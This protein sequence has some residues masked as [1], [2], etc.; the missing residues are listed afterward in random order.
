MKL[1]TSAQ[2][3]QWDLFTM[4]NESVSEYNLMERAAAGAA[5]FI[6]GQFS[7]NLPVYVFCGKGNNGADGLVISRKLLEGGFK[8][9]TF[10]IEY[11]QSASYLFSK[12]YEVLQ[13][14]LSS[15]IIHLNA[16]ELPVLD[17]GAIIIDA[18]FGSSLR[19][20]LPP[21]VAGII[22]QLNECRISRQY[23]IVAIDI[24]T[25]LEA[26]FC[27]PPLESPLQVCITLSFQIPKCSF[28][29][30][31]TG[32]YCGEVNILDIG[33]DKKFPIDQLSDYFLSDFNS[34]KG[35][36]KKRMK[37]AHK[38]NFGHSLII[39]GSKGKTGAAVLAAKGC[40]HAGA[41]LVTLFIHKSGLNTVQISV[42][43]AMAVESNET[44]FAAGFDQNL[45]L[46][47]SI[48]VGPGLG[49]QEQTKKNLIDLLK[50]YTKP[51]ILDADA[52]N[53]LSTCENW[54]TLIPENSI[55][56]PHPGEFDR[57]MGK[58]PT[59]FDRLQKQ[60]RLAL[61]TRSV[62]ILKGAYTSICFPSGKTWFNASGNPGMATG[63]SGDTLTGILCAL[64][65][66]GYSSENASR[67]GVYVHGLAADLAAEVH[68]QTALS[69]GM[70]SDFLGK[71]FRK[72][73][74]LAY[75]D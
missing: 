10:I 70:L 37:F 52:L 30:S 72:F 4:A 59:A 42:P 17:N 33:L 68:G 39:A 41:G 60:Q 26:N 23:K 55:L 31:D 5:S 2:I 71:A 27:R 67:L 58:S 74:A 32:I 18:I 47:N 1:L 62:I 8:V 44:D 38:G 19:L 66:Q 6:S 48:A 53:I 69:A 40:L 56:T 29:L 64:C 50:N 73:E 75:N 7:R 49:Q 11:S 34:L 35:I 15:E 22:R 46:Y 28:L 45:N 14:C 65:S 51:L 9:I 36:F 12:N 54:H 16:A 43:E 3:H 21:V 24:P 63:G 13:N 57:L 20:P 25:G 61:T